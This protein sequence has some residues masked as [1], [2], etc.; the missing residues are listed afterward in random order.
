MAYPLQMMMMIMMIAHLF[1]IHTRGCL[2]MFSSF[3]F[4]SIS[5]SIFLRLTHP[6]DEIIS[7]NQSS[8]TKVYQSVVDWLMSCFQVV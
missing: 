8:F 5:V 4:F 7:E 1:W 2:C 3:C 6:G